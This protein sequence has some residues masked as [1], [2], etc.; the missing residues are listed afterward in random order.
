MFMFVADT[1]AAH[2]YDAKGNTTLSWN[3]S[4]GECWGRHAGLGCRVLG[5]RVFCGLSQ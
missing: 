1:G 5:F 4:Q 2:L 3:D